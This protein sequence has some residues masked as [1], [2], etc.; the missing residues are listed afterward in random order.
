MSHTGASR[1]EVEPGEQAQ[2]PARREQPDRPPQSGEDEQRNAGH[3]L[4]PLHDRAGSD[5]G[6]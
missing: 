2:D 3:G 6:R 1:Q 5:A 4:H